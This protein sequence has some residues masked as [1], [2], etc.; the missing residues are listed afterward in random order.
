MEHT[1]QMD[2]QKHAL[3]LGASYIN[4][5]VSFSRFDS[6]RRYF[7]IDNAYLLRKLFLIVY[8]YNGNMWQKYTD[9]DIPSVSIGHPD[10]YIPLMAII[11]YVLCIACE[12]EVQ[13][14]FRPETLGKITT[15]SLLL[16]LL[17]TAVIKAA[18]FFF[19]STSLDISV[20]LSFIGYKYV[21]IT[22]MKIISTLFPI[23]LSKMSSI[24]LT[25]SFALFL[26]KSL[27]YFLISNDHEITIK[28]RKMYFLFSI[29]ILESILL[30]ALK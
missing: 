14:K 28:K 18:S 23:M 20:I 9:R 24:F 26:G 29:V 4:R 8:P 5:A 25:I 13:G 6:V 22:I 30:L 16:A 17:E 11:T 7:Q 2:M 19:D 1:L 15:K 10:L 12:M 27:K 21:T 3:N